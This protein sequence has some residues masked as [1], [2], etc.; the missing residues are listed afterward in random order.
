MIQILP[1]SAF[2]IFLLV[3]LLGAIFFFASS[4]GI[5]RI[6]EHATPSQPEKSHDQL[7]KVSTRIEAVPTTVFQLHALPMKV[8]LPDL[9]SH[10]LY[11][12]SLS[13]PDNEDSSAFLAIGL[14]GQTEL[15]HT[16][17]DSPL[18]LQFDNEKNQWKPATHS[19]LKVTF[20]PKEK[21][22][23]VSQE[24]SLPNGQTFKDPQKFASFTLS[25][26]PIPTQK[27]EEAVS[28][29][30][31]IVDSHFW[32]LQDALWWG[33]DA[34]YENLSEDIQKKDSQRILLKDTGGI[35]Y[36]LWVQEGD[37]F[38]YKKGRWTA[39]ELGAESR[40]QTLLYA[41]SISEK[42]IE[43]ELWSPNSTS[44]ALLPLIKKEPPHTDSNIDIN[45]VGTR[46]RNTW[47]ANIHG[48]RTLLRTDD[49]F[50][51]KGDTIE[52]LEQQNALD[53]YI[54]GQS[55]GTLIAF[56][57]IEHIDNEQK[58]IWIV[59][60]PTRTKTTP[61]SISLFHSWEAKKAPPSLKTGK[62][63]ENGHHHE[64]DEDDDDEDMEDMDEDS[65]YEDE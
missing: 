23:E 57:G 7:Q 26:L 35:L 43:F 55:E 62:T 31:M 13:R 27:Q 18:Y 34:L 64:D 51:V 54:N 53:A 22:L 9:R 40:K 37:G 32:E 25:L 10:L 29:D 21:I 38:V 15:I 48:Q 49:W 46:S 1:S 61:I 19:P 59:I 5:E 45:L 41:K 63:S 42:T 33:K 52:K 24:I 28:L 17:A 36:T 16:K 2:S 56:S 8:S 12:G 44:R 60:D 58:L 3:Q 11:Y 6:Q 65:F 14:R 30:G 47:I 39:V 20:Q 4:P 50:L